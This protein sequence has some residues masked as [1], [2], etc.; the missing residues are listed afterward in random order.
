MFRHS[1]SLCSLIGAGLKRDS[2]VT[3][4]GG[5]PLGISST[6]SLRSESPKLSCGC[7]VGAAAV[8]AVAAD[9]AAGAAA[10]AAFAAGAVEDL[11]LLSWSIS[12][13]KDTPKSLC[14]IS[15]ETLRP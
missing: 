3:L 11:P 13:S 8:F 2:L 4:E 12:F 5:L 7:L 1:K 6:F 15:C 14:F 10:P 9:D